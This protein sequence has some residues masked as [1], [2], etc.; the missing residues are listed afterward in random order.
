MKVITTP[1]PTLG[2][3]WGD[4]GLRQAQHGYGEVRPSTIDNGG[5][6]GGTVGQVRWLSWGGERAIATA[7]GNYVAPGK[8]MYEAVPA[9]AT[10]VAFNLG[11]CHDAPAYLS[12]EWYFPEH[13]ES[14]DPAKSWNICNDG[15]RP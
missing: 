13:G 2:R 9:R 10:V 7:I 5:D 12:I 1:A 4:K 3:P 15:P 11:T 8:F 6:E 14:F